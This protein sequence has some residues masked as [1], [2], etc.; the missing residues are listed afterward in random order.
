MRDNS[1]NRNVRITAI[2]RKELNE[3]TEE[4]L[5]ELREYAKLPHKEYYIPLIKEV[6]EFL[7]FQKE[8]YQ[9]EY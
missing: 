2:L 6:E 8:Y 3:I 9:K 7:N 5:Q 1:L 4:D